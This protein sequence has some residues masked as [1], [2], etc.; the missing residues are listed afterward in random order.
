MELDTKDYSQFNLTIRLG[1]LLSLPSKIFHR[2]RRIDDLLN[3]DLDV[4]SA[5]LG[6]PMPM[7]TAWSAPNGEISH[8]A[9]PPPAR[10]SLTYE[11]AN[12]PGPFAFVTSGY[13]L[14]LVALVRSRRL[15]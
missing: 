9:R 14:V 15:V 13:A 4:Q 5:A 8:I 2:L 12:M 10:N 7:T 11:L 6:M 3:H 1:S